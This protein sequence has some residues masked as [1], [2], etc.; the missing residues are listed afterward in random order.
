MSSIFAHQIFQ[1]TWWAKK[2]GIKTGGNCLQASVIYNELSILSYSL[3]QPPPLFFCWNQKDT[4][5]VVKHDLLLLNTLSLLLPHPFFACRCLLIS[6]AA[7][8]YLNQSA[9]MTYKFKFSRPR[10]RHEQILLIPSRKLY[11]I[12]RD[13]IALSIKRSQQCARQNNIYSM[14]KKINK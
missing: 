2:T 1:L 13:A 9:L 12:I 7:P 8:S 11:Q 6:L 3:S 10:Y 4:S 5:H 14:I